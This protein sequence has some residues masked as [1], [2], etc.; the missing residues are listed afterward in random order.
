MVVFFIVN[1]LFRFVGLVYLLIMLFKKIVLSVV[2]VQSETIFK[3]P[4]F[5]C[6]SCG[7][8][9]NYVNKK[10]NNQ[11]GDVGNNGL[12]L[13]VSYSLMNIVIS[14][15]TGIRLI[16]VN[17]YSPLLYRVIQYLQCGISLFVTL[18]SSLLVLIC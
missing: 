7:R 1:H 14:N 3:N 9:L 12:M 10:V 17:M 13:S 16:L 18:T 8:I 15:Q 11:H 5:F 6:P 2:S 4:S